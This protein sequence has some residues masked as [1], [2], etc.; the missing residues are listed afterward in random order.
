[1]LFQDLMACD[2][3]DVNPQGGGTPYDDLYGETLPERDT[4]LSLQVYETV[5]ISLVEVYE[6]VGNTVI[7]VIK[8]IKR[9]NMHFMA[10]GKLRK[11]FGF[12]IYF[13]RWCIFSSY[14]GLKAL[15]L[16]C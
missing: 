13:K 1:M 2:K 4:F 11:H 5:G 8:R 12:V 10:V 3:L 9:A 14:K 15:N 16:V 6:R 7:L